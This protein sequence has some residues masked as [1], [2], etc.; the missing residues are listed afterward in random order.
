MSK[1]VININKSSIDKSTICNNGCAEYKQS[2]A[3]A[4]GSINLEKSLVE[5]SFV[6]NNPVI[7]NISNERPTIDDFVCVIEKIA[8]LVIDREDDKAEVPMFVKDK[9]K[10]NNLFE[11]EALVNDYGLY[12]DLINKSQKILDETNPYA[13]NR[14]IAYIQHKYLTIVRNAD[15]NYIRLNATKIWEKIYSEIIFEINTNSSATYALS[16]LMCYAFIKCKIYAKVSEET[17]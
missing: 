16:Y 10:Y 5:N 8:N 11:L 17:L 4:T 14:M 6:A 9:I 12:F 1:E 13:F 7:I 3:E 2:S 15:I